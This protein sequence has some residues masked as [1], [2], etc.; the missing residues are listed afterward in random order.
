MGKDT[1][2]FLLQTLPSGERYAASEIK[3]VKAESLKAL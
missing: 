3:K 1:E 2:G